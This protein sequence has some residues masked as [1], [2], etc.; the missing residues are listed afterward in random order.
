M[1]IVFNVDYRTNW[2]ESLFVVGA[3][4]R[5]GSWNTDAANP[6]KLEGYQRWTAE[7]DIPAN[8]RDFEYGRIS[9]GTNHTTLRL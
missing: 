8:T 5:L 2:G 3:P 1:K 6:M 4:A 9:P 7:V